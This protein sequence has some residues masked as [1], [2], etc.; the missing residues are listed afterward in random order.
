MRPAILDP[1]F[2][3]VSTL[4]GVG[5]KLADLLAKL[6]SRENADDT[7]VIDLLFHAPSNVIDRRNRPG[8]ALAAPGAIVTIRGRVDRHQPA[9]P[10]NRS[11]PYRV[12]LHDETGEL[13]LTFFRA[14]GDWLSRPCR[15]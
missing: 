11:A 8:I 2:A 6:L 7:R 13:A 14:K 4:A 15:R 3:S 9:P 5:P 1:L 10:G 12:F